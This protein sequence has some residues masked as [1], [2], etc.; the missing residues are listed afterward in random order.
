MFQILLISAGHHDRRAPSLAVPTPVSG[1][2]CPG[3]A[4]GAAVHRHLAASLC[5]FRGQKSGGPWNS[6]NP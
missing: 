5:S 4:N 6:G 1:S 3:T 2:V